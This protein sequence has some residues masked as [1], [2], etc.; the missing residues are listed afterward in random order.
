MKL[1]ILLVGLPCA[2]LAGR[3]A[4]AFWLG[5]AWETT[6][7]LT[8]EDLDIMRTTVQRDIHGK[9]ADT[10]ATWQNPTSGNSGTITLLKKATRNGKA[11]EQI[12][13]RIKPSPPSTRWERY[14]FTS[15]HQPDGTWKLES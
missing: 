13:Y 9:R 14:V 4:Q 7:T 10:V 1:K 11:C 2:L 8:S 3:A 6:T 5:P 12:E 15:C